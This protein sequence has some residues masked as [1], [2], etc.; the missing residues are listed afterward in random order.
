[1]TQGA[2]GEWALRI[3]HIGFALVPGL[4]AKPIADGR[5][6]RGFTHPRRARGPA[7]HCRDEGSE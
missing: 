7:Q 4:D 1:M 5:R 2:A 3:D 6:D